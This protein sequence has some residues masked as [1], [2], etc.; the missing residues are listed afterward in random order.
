M[1]FIKLH[2]LVSVLV[3]LTSM[4][5]VSA[6]VRGAEEALI[7]VA[8]PAFPATDVSYASLKSAFRGQRISIGGKVI[9]PINHPLETPL[10]VRFDRIALGLEPQAVG[11]FWIDQRIRDQGR[12]PTT[13]STP[14]LAL[15]IVAVLAGAVTYTTKSAL[16]G[17]SP[18]KVLTIDGASAGQLGYPLQP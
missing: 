17:R 2:V 14:E 5:I 16:T 11:G 1:R 12:P 9:I 13:A 18:V 10:R 15:K 6:P 4:S 7:I 3:F 8:G